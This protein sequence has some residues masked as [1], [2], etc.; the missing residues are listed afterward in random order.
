MARLTPTLLQFLTL[1]LTALAGF[2]L[3][4]RLLALAGGSNRFPDAY[5]SVY[6]L[7]IRS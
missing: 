4:R 6:R 2:F 7:I 3:L 1:P 5:L